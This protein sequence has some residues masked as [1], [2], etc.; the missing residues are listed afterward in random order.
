MISN[1]RVLLIGSGFMAREYLKVLAHLG[2]EVI[3]VGRSNEKIQSLKSDY[4]NFAYFFGGL[5]K[6]LDE[7]TEI[8]E[9]AINAAS[10]NQL[11]SISLLLMDAGVK[12]LMLE[13][14][15]ELTLAGLNE[16]KLKAIELSVDV[17]IAYNRRFYSSITALK[18]QVAID[19]GI[20]SAH[21]E[22]TEWV[23]TIDPVIYDSEALNKWIISN[24]SHVI[25]TVFSLIGVPKELNSHV[26]GENVITWHPTGS[27]FTG[28]GI[29]DCDIPFTYHSNWEGPGRWAIEV[30][31]RNRRFYLKPMEKLFQQLKGRVE[32]TEIELDS[33]LDVNYKPGLFNQTVNFLNQNFENFLKLEDQ[34]SI[35]P[36]YLKMGGYSFQ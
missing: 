5:N 3:V 25:D 4:P 34:I 9:F 19:G 12:Y 7:H 33:L 23:H 24:S 13:K 8:P 35:I 29:S 27:I 28:S 18:E 26:G 2:N 36:F 30:S 1:S 16:I 15:G 21:F 14:P 22:F 10:I 32:I 6:Y 20:T 11:K 31:T 17:L